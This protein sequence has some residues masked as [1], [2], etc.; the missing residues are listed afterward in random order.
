M[1]VT[2]IDPPA[3]VTARPVPSAIAPIGLDRLMGMVA[4]AGVRT[5]AREAITPLA[6]AF[7]FIPLT[8]QLY[9]PADKA[10]DTDLLPAT[11]DGPAV[12]ATEAMEAA[13]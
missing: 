9:K 6:I 7:W 5:N 1:A 11:A 3:D 2:V 10:H 13:G 4:A 12:A 8:R